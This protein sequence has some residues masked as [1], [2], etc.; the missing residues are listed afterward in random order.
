MFREF[1][2]VGEATLQ[3]ALGDLL[4][5]VAEHETHVQ[6][7]KNNNVFYLTHCN[8]SPFL[9]HTMT[10]HIYGIWC[11]VSVPGIYTIEP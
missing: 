10:V 6:W 4:L 1:R 7:V 3:S 8:S 9:R 2:R 11:A 5:L